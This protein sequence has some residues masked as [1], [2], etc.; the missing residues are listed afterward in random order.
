M[1]AGKNP[2][3][4]IRLVYKP[5]STA[6]K[7][8]ILA[9]LVLSTAAMLLL[10]GAIADAKRQEEA[11]RQ[12]AIHLEQRNEALDEDISQLGTVQSVKDLAG[13]FLGLV[14]PGTKI[15]LPEQ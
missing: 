2:F 3:A 14:D 12:K 7:C 5:S 11:M 10:R 6:V 9:A 13:R 1:A 8:I 15:F 4:R